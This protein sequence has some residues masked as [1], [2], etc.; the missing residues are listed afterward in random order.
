MTLL[1]P[2][3]TA[4]IAALAA[5]SGAGASA[6][7]YGFAGVP[8][9][10]GK[11]ADYDTI[12]GALADSGAD[13]FFPTFLFQQAPQ[14]RS[15]GREKDFAPPCKPT[16]R[17][18]EALRRSGLGLIVPAS[19]LY[20]PRRPL[21][22]V[23]RD[24][25]RA[26]MACAGPGTVRGVF[27]YD[28]PVHAGVSEDAARLLYARVKEVAPDLPVMMVHAPMTT[29]TSAEAH[30]RYMAAV[31]SI[32]RHADVVGFDVYPVPGVI[33]KIVRPGSGTTV[34]EGQ[35]AVRAYGRLIRQLAPDKRHLAVLQNF[36]Y[37]D[38][39]DPGVLGRFPRR[40]VEAA[41]GPTL[42]ELRGMARAAEEEGAEIIF[43]FGGAYTPDAG[44]AHWKRSLEVTRE[45]ADR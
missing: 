10:L 35:E 41:R 20:D 3:R 31:R 7:E 44:A 39:F 4:V 43:W 32:S 13:F 11:T 18:F 16:D 34:L 29:D 9:S 19:L 17:A 2:V 28:E 42:G 21:P 14:P 1:R 40:L 25:L 33:A 37:V 15:L 38:Q 45:R 26:L 6:V 36:A 22:P 8:V 5:F 27:S 24:P 12:F 30:Q 23:G